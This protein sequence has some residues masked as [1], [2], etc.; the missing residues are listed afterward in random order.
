MARIVHKLKYAERVL[1]LWSALIIAS[2][3]GISYLP[4]NVIFKVI[5]YAICFFLNYKL[6]KEKVE[7]HEVSDEKLKAWK[8]KRKEL[9]LAKLSKETYN[10]IKEFVIDN[11]RASATLIERTFDLDWHTAD[12]V[13][14]KLYEEGI[15]G[16]ICDHEPREVLVK[17]K[18]KE[19]DKNI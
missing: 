6:I 15:V 2:V 11:Q 14:N 9:A 5:G 19:N 8:Q 3:I 1:Q 13:I 12:A 18:N 10:K 16:E 7:G 4:I 17:K